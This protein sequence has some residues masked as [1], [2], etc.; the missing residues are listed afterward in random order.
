M[1]NQLS[2]QTVG[3]GNLTIKPAAS[4]GYGS[5]AHE[6]KLLTRGPLRAKG[7]VSPTNRTEKAIIK[8]AN[9]S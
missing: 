5:I 6:V 8:L 3:I 1:T 9:A 2:T 4:K 7:S